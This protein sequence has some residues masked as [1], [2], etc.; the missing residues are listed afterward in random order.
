MLD[1]MINKEWLRKQGFFGLEKRRLRGDLF[2]VS[3]YLKGSY[4]E[5]R[6]RSQRC[7]ARKKR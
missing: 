7:M 2:A 3:N 6:T 4:K 5:D 1:S